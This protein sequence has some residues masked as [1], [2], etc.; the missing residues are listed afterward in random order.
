[1]KRP[2]I[3]VFSL[4]TMIFSSAQAAEPDAHWSYEGDDGPDNWGELSDKYSRCRDGQNQSPVD[5]VA[6]YEVDLPELVFE[7]HGT[8]LKE[9]NNG[10]TIMLNVTKGN[11]L[12]VPEKNW[13]FELQQGHFHSPSEHTINGEHFPME[14]HLV[15]TG[16]KGELVVVGVMVE[17][18]EEDPML[19]R[20]WSFM[21]EA[22]GETRESPLTVFEAGVMPPTRDYFSY[23][24]SLT[25]PP[26]SEGVSW[27][28][29][30]EPLTASAE[31]VERFKQRVGP[32]TNRPIQPKNAR[33]ILD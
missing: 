14:I 10:H 23:D 27:I 24:G 18:G 19:N 5:L 26:C 29:L 21:P 33:V 9:T 8:P 12:S 28:V 7:Y 25:T 4:I 32:S 2:L 20:I 31:Q 11:F 16:S 30:H 22:V 17:E 15:H 13:K 1:M 3:L 6:D